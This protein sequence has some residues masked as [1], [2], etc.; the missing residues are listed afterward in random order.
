[1][2]GTN[3]E[4]CSK[5]TYGSEKGIC[6]PADRGYYVDLTGQTTQ[7]ECDDNTFSNTIG[8]SSCTPFTDCNP[9]QKIKNNGDEQNDRECQDC[10]FGYYSSNNN[11]NSC[12]VID[13]G[14]KAV[15]TNNKNTAQT[16]CVDNTYSTD[17]ISEDCTA[18]SLGHEIQKENNK[19]IGEIRCNIG[20]YSNADTNY[21][22]NPCP[23]GSYT[24]TNQDSCSP[25]GTCPTGKYRSGCSGS[26]PGK[27]TDCP[28]C[29]AGQFRSGC[30]GTSPGT[31]TEYSTKTCA[32]GQ[33][34]VIGNGKTDNS[35]YCQDCPAGYYNPYDNASTECYKCVEGTY[36]SSP[37]SNMCHPHANSCPVGSVLKGG[38][39]TSNK[40]CDT[41]STG[42]YSYGGT[43]TSCSTCRTCSPNQYETQS[44]TPTQNRLCSNCRT[45]SPNQYET[46][47]C[48]PTQNRLC[49]NCKTC[50]DHEYES[51]TCTDTQNTECSTCRTCSPN[52]YESSACIGTQN[53]QCTPYLTTCPNGQRLVGG[54]TTSNKRCEN[55]LTGHYSDGIT[56]TQ[57]RAGYEINSNNNGEEPCPAGKFSSAGSSSC[58]PCPAGTFSSSSGSTSCNSCPAG[59]FS[60]EG[61]TSCST[62]PAGK[63]SSAGSPLCTNCPGGTFSSSSGSTSCNSCPAGKYS[64]A[65]SRYCNPCPAG[66][67]SSTGWHSCQ[68]CTQGTY[69]NKVGESGCNT[70]KKC[71]DNQYESHQC[72]TTQNTICSNCGTCPTGQYRSGCSGTSEGSCTNCGTCPAGYERHGC[73]PTSQGTCKTCTTVERVKNAYHHDNR[74]TCTNNCK[75]EF[76]DPR[77]SQSDWIVVGEEQNS[78]AR[79][80]IERKNGGSI[81]SSKANFNGTG[82]G[83]EAGNNIYFWQYAPI[84]GIWKWNL[85]LNPRN[86]QGSSSI[87]NP[88]CNSKCTSGEERHWI[89]RIPYQQYSNN[90]GCIGGLVNNNNHLYSGL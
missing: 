60:S 16:L 67:V 40:Y 18:L 17:E 78:D 85:I 84:R 75:V 89:I 54:S 42:Y 70:C 45:C 9:G 81:S 36:S 39:S 48:T 23:S 8:A 41:C 55:C 13:P 76:K 65:G 64:S 7:K 73:T 29:P 26:S 53:R 3:C 59:E 37:R 34:L 77:L 63:F 25:C 46:Q 51:K 21:I 31:C 80:R 72:T 33:K 66:S 86:Y 20:S 74:N 88:K 19:N 35:Q 87:N 50:G 5:G 15:K 10:E 47:S 2:Q 62:C 56:C 61:S 90:H 44:C 83:F 12:L 28:E 22:C 68:T 4:P 82:I 38:S 52:Q 27:C 11:S 79:V 24:N 14:Y 32:P 43:N 57:V 49:S 71:G 58:S 30:S 1:M 6:K 69:Q